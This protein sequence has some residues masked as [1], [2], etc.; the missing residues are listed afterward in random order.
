MELGEVRASLMA[1]AR[2]DELSPEEEADFEDCYLGAVGY[3]ET[4]GVS[5]PE[6]G[7]L[8]W[9]QY[10]RCLKALFLDDWDH[11]GTAGSAQGLADNPAFRRRINQLKLTEAVPDSGTANGEDGGNG[12]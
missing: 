5:C 4:A 8:R 2:I 10:M 3:L 12:G 9:H 1:Y 11:R 7:T 6:V